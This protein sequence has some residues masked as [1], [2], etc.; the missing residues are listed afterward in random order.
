MRSERPKPLHLLCGRP[1]VV[2][3]LDALEGLDIERTV[4]VVGHGAE[5][6]TKKV[7]AEPAEPA[8]RVRRAARPAGH[9]R[10][11]EVGLTAFADDDLD[12]TSTVAGA[13][14][15]HTAAAPRD[16][17][18]AG[19]LPRG[20][21]PRRHDPHRAHGRPHRLR[22]AGPR[23]GRPRR[24]RRRGGRRHA[25]GASHRRGQ[26]LHLLLP[27]QPPRPGAAAGL[28][29]Q[30]P[31]RVLP[32]RRHRRAPRRR[33][34]GSTPFTIDDAERGPGRQR[35]GQLALAEAELRRRTNRRWLLDGR[36][37]ARSRARPTSTRPSSSAATSRCSRARCS[38]AR[39]V[40]GDGCEIGPDTRARRLR[41]SATAPS[42]STPWPARAE[43]GDGARVGPYA[44]LAAGH[45]RP[46]RHRDRRLLHW[47]SGRRAEAQE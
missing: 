23:Q 11:G 17:R 10:R 30:R 43:I 2:H 33:L 41:A 27:A 14:R 40:V 3:V 12:D 15:R 18:R 4:V 31:G 16:P 19:G 29:R 7:Q 32:D 28:A 1:M 35:P 34:P 9:R 42:S 20:R 5:R 8:R 39:T 37:D 36:H 6:V 47:R 13:P 26:H 21:G 38:R 44:V 45:R 25:G 46:V 24:Q 22:A